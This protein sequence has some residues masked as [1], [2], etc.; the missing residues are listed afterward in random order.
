MGRSEE[1]AL[2]IAMIFFFVI[3]FAFVLILYPFMSGRGDEEWVALL[4][5]LF[6]TWLTHHSNSIHNA[7]SNR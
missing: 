6:L 4:N 3:V 2:E 1:Y 7:T 5:T